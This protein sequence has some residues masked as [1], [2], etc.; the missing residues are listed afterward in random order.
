MLTAMM[1]KKWGTSVNNGLGVTSG[2]TPIKNWGGSAKDYNFSYYRHLDADKVNHREVK[3]YHCYSCILGCGGICDIRNVGDGK[4]PQTHKPEYETCAAFGGLVMN[5][6]L[7]AIFYINE[8]L[9]RAGMDSISA[10]ATVAYAVE[11]YENGILT[12]KDTGGL[13]LNWGNAQSIITL[14]EKMI[15]REG[16]GD[17]LADGVKAAS[18]R[19]GA[20]SNEFVVHAG[21]QEP[22]M[23]DSRYDP[24]LG[25][26]YSADP[27]PGR[28]TI[29]GGQ[30]YDSMQLW[31]KV[32]WAPRSGFHPKSE[33]Y[34]ASDKTA[35]KA[36]ANSCY[37]EVLDGAGG[38]FFAMIEGVNHWKMFEWLNAATGW[39]KT[40]DEYMEIGK[41][42]QTLRQMF[43]IKQGVDPKQFKMSKRMTGEPPLKEGPLKGKQ[44]PIEAMMNLYWKHYGWDENTGIPLAET[45]TLLQLDELTERTV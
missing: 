6:D 44:V 34:E 26:H 20:H 15:A 23:H 5:K 7:D 41:R 35:L 31:E 24:L 32:S 1:F 14:V 28:H 9:N 29:G 13:A 8:L 27:T 37:K 33:D 22:G 12:D 18:A 11:C 43:N 19:I 42:I 16:I 45:V 2:D 30:Y 10:G 25:I 4:F 40:P 17:V 21:G 38:C 36:V 39:E 3:K